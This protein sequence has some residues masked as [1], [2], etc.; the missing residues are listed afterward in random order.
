M[1]TI[2]AINNDIN[3]FVSGVDH[4]NTKAAEIS[5]RCNQQLNYY[6]VITL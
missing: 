4:V 1:D 2:R 5:D 6:K 3:A